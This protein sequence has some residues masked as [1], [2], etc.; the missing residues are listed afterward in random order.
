MYFLCF[1]LFLECVLIWSFVSSIFTAI[2]RAINKV[3]FL[4]TL[5]SEPE[6]Y[7]PKKYLRV[8]KMLLF[9]TIF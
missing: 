3:K 1:P 9:N 5:N 7:G 2:D 6:Y 8:I 4:N